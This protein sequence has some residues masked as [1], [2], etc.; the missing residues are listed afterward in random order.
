[1]TNLRVCRY[2]VSVLLWLCSWTWA[3]DSTCFLWAGLLQGYVALGKWQ[4]C[5]CEHDRSQVYGLDGKD[6]SGTD[7][8]EDEHQG[9]LSG[10][11]NSHDNDYRDDL[12]DHHDDGLAEV[13]MDEDDHSF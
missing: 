7:V 9:L 4:P 8:G 3:S 13:N 2:L 6:Y 10:D 12:N 1:M 11:P 5:P